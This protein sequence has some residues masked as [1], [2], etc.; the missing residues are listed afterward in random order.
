MQT[1]LKICWHCL[2]RARM[3]DVPA[4]DT[5]VLLWRLSQDEAEAARVK[6]SLSALKRPAVVSVSLLPGKCIRFLP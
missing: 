4:E 6:D 3:F 5:K 1:D 2:N